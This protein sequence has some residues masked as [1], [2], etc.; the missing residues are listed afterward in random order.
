[1][2]AQRYTRVAVALHWLIAVLI[3]SNLAL[4]FTAVWT[5]GTV[6]RLTLD[7]HK[8]I[9]IAILTLSIV[10]IGWRIAH[11]PPPPVPSAAWQRGLATATHAA[12]YFLII[13]IPLTGWWM[14]SAVPERHPIDL[15]LFTVPFLPTR[16]G[17]DV[18]GPLHAT[19]GWLAYVM[20]GLLALHVLAAMKH[21]YRDRDGLISRMTFGSSDQPRPYQGEDNVRS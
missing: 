15:G 6:H 4:G 1:M 3:V 12:F 20:L 9:G 19:H 10:R 13:A 17:F 7:L 14:S 8:P 2:I 21:Q 18:A 16:R 11:R 5:E